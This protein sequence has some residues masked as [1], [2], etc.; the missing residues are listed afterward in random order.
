MVYVKGRSGSPITSTIH[1]LGMTDEPI[2][3]SFKYSQKD[4]PA[5][6]FGPEVPANILSQLYEA[7]IRMNLVHFDETILRACM[8]ESA[9]AAG[10]FDGVCAPGGTPL[11]N[12]GALFSSNNYFISLNI[13]GLRYPLPWRFPAS[14]LITPLEYPIGS[15]ATKPSLVWRSIPYA[16]L[17]TGA[18]YTLPSLP[19]VTLR[20]TRGDL[21]SYGAVV[22]DHTLD[23]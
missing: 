8:R 18:A 4:V 3:I 11:G 14:F 23:S 16:S 5:D 15:V 9:V 21:L 17:A 12:G 19:G 13:V 7:T 22:W 10:N 1:E 20:P 2:R 6:D